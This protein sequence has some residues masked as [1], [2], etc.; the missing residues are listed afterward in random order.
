MDEKQT[1]VAPPTWVDHTASDDRRVMDTRWLRALY[2][3]AE[4]MFAGDRGLPPPARLRWLCHDTQDFLRQIRGRGALVFR[5][6]LLL[7]SIVAPLFV[8]RPLPLRALSYE[9]RCVALARYERSPL[10][11]SLFVL[12]AILCIVW[13]EHPD[14]AREVGFDGSSLRRAP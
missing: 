1:A 3:V 14:S 12:K 2:A 9:R 4:V 11:L 8:L 13:F 5:L 10:G 7:V 6:A